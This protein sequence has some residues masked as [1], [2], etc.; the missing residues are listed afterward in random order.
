MGF[1][2]SDLKFWSKKKTNYVLSKEDVLELSDREKEIVNKHRQDMAEFERGQVVM[3]NELRKMLRMDDNDEK[4]E[5]EKPVYLYDFLGGW[6]EGNN[7]I[8]FPTNDP[9]GPAG[10]VEIA[11]FDGTITVPSVAFGNDAQGSLASDSEIDLSKPPRQYK[12]IEVWKELEEVPNLLILENLDD[13]IA[14]LK[15]KKDLIK[16]NDYCK[17][18]MIDM[19]TR[20]ENRKKYEEHKGYFEQ[21]SNTTTEKVAALVE[22]YNLVLESA[23]LFIPKFPDEAIAIMADYV[24]GVKAVCGKT[25]IFYVIAE[26]SMFKEEYKRND[27]IL[28]VQSPFGAYWQVLGAWDKEMILLEYL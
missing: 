22:K 16:K 4:G 5:T 14:V 10:G 23:D 9:N 26:K 2:L 17:R 25:P 28:L 27:P 24:D 6:K 19:V 8:V 20:L 18:E 11:N 7:T 1:K 3:N 21:Y 13:K 15:L 12:P